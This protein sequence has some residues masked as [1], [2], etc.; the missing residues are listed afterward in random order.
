MSKKS[1]IIFTC[2]DLMVFLKEKPGTFSHLKDTRVDNRDLFIANDFMVDCEHASDE[3]GENTFNTIH[4]KIGDDWILRFHTYI[5][6]DDFMG[7]NFYVEAKKVLEL[8]IGPHEN[9]QTIFALLDTNSKFI[10]D[11]DI[12]P[13]IIKMYFAGLIKSS[14]KNARNK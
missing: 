13:E 11:M 12:H 10:F 1:E 14:T 8:R 9:I 7:I 3:R 5:H 2:E 4:E 6:S